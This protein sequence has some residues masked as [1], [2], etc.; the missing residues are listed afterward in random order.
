MATNKHIYFL[1]NVI[2]QCEKTNVCESYAIFQMLEIDILTVHQCKIQ[3]G[4]VVIFYSLIIKIAIWL[5]ENHKN[6]FIVAIANDLDKYSKK[7]INSISR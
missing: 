1:E 2:Y 6:I 5:F 3:K 4:K 7:Q